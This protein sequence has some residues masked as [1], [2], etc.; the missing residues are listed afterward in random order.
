MLRIAGVEENPG[1][2]ETGEW[3]EVERVR[4]R[5]RYI[6]VCKECRASFKSA[7]V[8]REGK[9][10]TFWGKHPFVQVKDYWGTPVDT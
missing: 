2:C 3:V 9:V 8:R 1:P 5:G 10:T 4:V 7:R 6:F